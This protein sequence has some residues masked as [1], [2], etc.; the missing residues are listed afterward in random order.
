MNASID[1][2][3]I[4]FHSDG[5]RSDSSAS[6]FRSDSIRSDSSASE[7]RPDNIGPEPG[8]LRFASVDDCAGRLTQTPYY[9]IDEKAL[10]EYADFLIRCMHSSWG[11]ILPSFSVKTNSL[12]WL[13]AH[14]RRKGFYAEIVS[15]EE[16]DLAKRVGY[17]PDQMIYNGPVKDRDVFRAVLLAGG[18]VNIDSH[19]EPQWLRELSREYPG[20]T[21]RVGVRTNFDLSALCP[22]EMTENEEGSRFGFSWEDGELA[23]VIQTLENI[24]GV[25]IAGLHLHLTTR[26]RNPSVTAMLCRMCAEV[27][28]TLHLHLS[29]V[30]V[31]GGFYGGVKGKP[32]YSDYFP[33]IRRELEGTFDPAQVTLIAE[34][35]VSLVSSS[36]YFVTSVR[37]VRKVRDNWYLVTDGSRLNMNP[38]ITR[39]WYPH[40]VL[41]R[42]AA[43]ESAPVP[44]QMVCGATCM[45]YDRLFPIEN[46]PLFHTGDKIV[47]DLAGGYTMCLNPNFIH[48]L[49]AVYVLKPDG[50]L[51]TARSPWTND[52]VMARNFWEK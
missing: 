39:R 17:T 28:R 31:G 41:R 24:P 15:A 51:I 9:L 44:Q 7:I 42:A 30:D 29:Y 8:S 27:A 46:E 22:E 37:D 26:S 36:F 11:K 45:E 16:Y 1:N 4:K 43:A 47:Y 40:H 21:F 35:G 25:E 5:I 48:Y 13:I 23:A 6:E 14:L 12:P 3:D 34:P 33:V 32:D 18:Y 38:Q 2:N 50:S 10:D 52:E 19:L 20:R 49:P